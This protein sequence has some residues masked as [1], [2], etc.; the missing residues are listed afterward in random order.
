VIVVGVC[1]PGIVL[2]SIID[3]RSGLQDLFSRAGRW[4]VSV[5]W[6]AVALLTSP[7]LM[8]AVLLAWSTLISPIFIPT[9]FP[10]GVVFGLVSGFLEDIGWR[11]YAFPRMVL[12]PS[13]LATGLLPGML[14]GLWHTPAVAASHGGYWLPF[15]LT[16][17]ASVI[18]IRVLIVW[19]YSNTSSLL[20]AQLMH[21]SFSASLITIT[22]L[23]ASL[24]QDTLRYA[25]CAFVLWVVVALVVVGY[26]KRLV[27][28]PEQVQ[29]TK[30]ALK[31]RARMALPSSV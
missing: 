2:T 14:W 7:V 21:A 15:F 25:V 19:V 18:A 6:Y 12:K 11:G 30:S 24:A 8:L 3:G 5:H 20:L 27:R 10:L 31:Y 26:G 29:V 13:T 23:H 1:L 28:Q 9:L 4:R 16:F 17:I 22:P